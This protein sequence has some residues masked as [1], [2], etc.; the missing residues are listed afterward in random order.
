MTAYLSISKSGSDIPSD[1]FVA[2]GRHALIVG[3]SGSGKTAAAKVLLDQDLSVGRHVVI[4]DPDNVYRDYASVAH[5]VKAMLDYLDSKPKDKGLRFV[6]EK[7]GLL[8]EALEALF[9]WADQHNK[10]ENAPAV[11]VVIDEL[12]IYLDAAGKDAKDRLLA[13][14]LK[15]AERGRF[16]GLWGTWVAQS[17]TQI[18][19]RV[20][21]TVRLALVGNQSERPDMKAIAEKT[22][23]DALRRLA[24]LR[25]AEFMVWAPGVDPDFIIVRPPQRG[26]YEPVT[27]PA[28]A[29]ALDTTDAY[30]DHYAELCDVGADML[31]AVH[32]DPGAFD[33]LARLAD[34]DD[35]TLAA[36][37]Q[38]ITEEL[39]HRHELP[40]QKG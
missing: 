4:F 5:T 34:I 13:I 6:S 20:R 26:R 15:I 35:S 22:G 16:R 10:K 7:A 32:N 31:K 30:S 37:L 1:S 36:A 14:L 33:L 19:D 18:P 9:K 23:V 11:T 24:K 27:D 3:A 39:K 2:S 40:K 28:L 21:H 17:F 38:F 29:A 25:L 12:P 8:V